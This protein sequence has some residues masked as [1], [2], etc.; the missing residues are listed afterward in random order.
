MPMVKFAP[1]DL[2]QMLA[3]RE[4]RSDLQTKLLKVDHSILT[5]SL[6]IAG[7]YKRSTIS[8]IYFDLVETDI[9]N[10][11]SYAGY[12]VVSQYNLDSFCGRYSI[13]V[14]SSPA[15]LEIKQLLIDWEQDSI[16]RRLVDID[17]IDENGKKVSRTDCGDQL[18]PCLICDRPA[19]VCSRERHHD[20]AELWQVAH[21]LMLGAIDKRQSQ[22]CTEC[23]LKGMLFEVASAPK[24]GLVDRFDSGIHHD[25][26]IYTFLASSAAIAPILQEF[27]TAGQQYQDQRLFSKLRQIGQYAERVMYRSTAGINTHKGLIFALALMIG[28]YSSLWHNY[29]TSCLE[30]EQPDRNT[31]P[32]KI[33][34]AL[35]NMD[36]WRRLIQL[37]ASYALADFSSIS[38]KNHLSA[39]EEL[40][41]S[42]GIYGA[43][44]EA[45]SGYATVFEH[46]LPALKSG[47][48]LFKNSELASCW[49]LLNI[50][51]ET[52]DT[53]LIKKLGIDTWQDYRRLIRI[54]LDNIEY[55][56]QKNSDGA[57]A[58]LNL[59]MTKLTSIFNQNQLSPGGSADLLALTIFVYELSKEFPK[60]ILK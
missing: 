55:F 47:Y 46:G 9:L 27:W 51:V 45:L 38:E 48:K 58:Q 56:L 14:I 42:Q 6:N 32:D 31:V 54:E 10:L 44:G 59:V 37:L 39:G 34:L 41:R 7:P 4:A 43:R 60:E 23:A 13:L 20:Y 5:I 21:R 49:C 28:S 16:D 25:M 11:L 50:M 52:E 18:R 35:P 57:T 33:D 19:F 17:V 26:D 29:F 24:P 15:A 3:A 30:D 36:D 2:Q 53:N 1:I 12:N 8:D 22:F 40:F